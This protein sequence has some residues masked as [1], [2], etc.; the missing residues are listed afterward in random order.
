M[1]KGFTFTRRAKILLPIIFVVILSAILLLVFSLRQ[2]AKDSIEIETPYCSLYYPSQWEDYLLTDTQKG[3][4]Y[5]VTFSAE[6]KGKAPL[7]LFAFTFGGEETDLGFIDM[8]DGST[9]AVNLI[10]YPFEE[11]S[12]YSSEETEIIY[13][14]QE[15]L[16]YVLE[17]LPLTGEPTVDNTESEITNLL[18]TEAE[19]DGFMSIE[20]KYGDLLYP[21][22]WE[23]HLSVVYPEGDD[24]CVAFFCNLPNKTEQ[25]L[26][27]VYFNSDNGFDAGTFTTENGESVSVTVEFGVSSLP[28]EWSDLECDLFFGMQEDVNYIIDKLAE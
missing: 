14:M 26:F 22:K 15:D 27:T 7:P 18:F 4:I 11:S 2:D 9:I 8:A 13:T 19:E 6:F 16:N 17:Q 20:T 10:I 12:D 1:K 3:D 25:P 24:Y 23:E 21:A 28:A 5:T